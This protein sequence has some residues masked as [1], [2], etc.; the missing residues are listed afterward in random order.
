MTLLTLG[1]AIWWVTHLFPLLA[2]DRRDRVAARLGE[3]PYKS[4]F[5]LVTLGAIALM[6]VGYKASDFVHVY[7]A[8]GWGVHLNNLLMLAAVAL[9]GAGHSKSRI[10]R[11]IRHPMLLGVIVWAV[12]HLL[13]NGDLSSLLLFGGLAAW[14]LVAI[15][16]TNAR[17]G[18]WARPEGGTLA[19]DIRLGVI[20]IAVY[21]ILAALHGYAFGVWPFPG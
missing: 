18:G 9:L 8:P 16:A 6:V 5:S 21:A 17:D 12:A 4:L 2:R 3:T 11:V 15:F 13:V 7:A 14:A 20:T 19:G 1:L 10:K